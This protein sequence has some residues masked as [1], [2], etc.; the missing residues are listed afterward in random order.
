MNRAVARQIEALLLASAAPVSQKKLEQHFG[1]SVNDELNELSIFWATRGVNIKRRED[2]IFFAP[3]DAV[4]KALDQGDSDNGRKLS[5]AAIETLC[6]IAIH[7]P[8]TIKDI[9]GGRKVKIF[10]GILESLL[11][12]GL[13]RATLK[14]SNTGRAVAY[15]TTDL[16][17]DH[18]N[19]TALTDLPSLDEMRDILLNSPEA[20]HTE[21][22]T[23]HPHLDTAFGFIT[24]NFSP[25]SENV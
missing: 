21:N 22:E 19:L 4:L 1:F 16:F 11:D 17:L 2:Q 8:V 23:P 24:S 9:E 13:I 20:N 5:E 6:Y 3:S 15:A 18:F 25:T 10:K 12:S 14:K 7:Q